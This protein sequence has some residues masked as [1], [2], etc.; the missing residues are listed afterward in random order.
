MLKNGHQPE[1]SYVKQMYPCLRTS[2]C[3]KSHAAKGAARTETASWKTSQEVS[4]L[5]LPR[6]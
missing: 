1:Y 4:L 6:C 3:K 2:Y 5:E